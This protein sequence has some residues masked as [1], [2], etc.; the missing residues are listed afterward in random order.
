MVVLVAAILSVAAY[1][2]K[3]AQDRNVE[4]ETKKN[5][6]KSI[7]ISVDAAEAEKI[8]EK[9][10]SDSYIVDI[11]GD[12]VDGEAFEVNL[13]KERSRPAAERNLPI[14]VAEID[15]G[16]KYIVPL[17]GAGLWGAIWGYIALN[18]DLNTIYGATFDHESETPGLGAEI[19]TEP[20][21]IPFKGKTIFSQSGKL[22]SIVVAKAG[23][24]AEAQHS[25]DAISGGTITCKGLQQMILDDLTTYQEF[26]KKVR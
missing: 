20:F 24:K 11:K 10:I 14:Y 26:F 9:T 25:V 1:S 13:K 17:R 18:D 6:L 19:A 22:V 7:N 3:P 4:I 15:G 8:F 5:I 21:Q 23:E 16:K 2:L 12:K